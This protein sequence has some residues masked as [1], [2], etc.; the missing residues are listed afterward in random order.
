MPAQEGLRKIS[1]QRQGTCRRDIKN[2]REKG[3]AMKKGNFSKILNVGGGQSHY[4]RGMEGQRR[5]KRAPSVK[6]VVWGRLGMEKASVE[7]K[8]AKKGRSER[9]RLRQ[10]VER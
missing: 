1:E 10:P 6:G 7:C 5:K 3:A 4:G 8:D 2:K 9:D